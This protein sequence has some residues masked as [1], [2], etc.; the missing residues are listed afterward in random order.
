MKKYLNRVLGLLVL[1]LLPLISYAAP[2]QSYDTG[3][4]Q[5]AVNTIWIV[6]DVD[7]LASAF[8][9]T[10][11]IFTAS[12]FN[13]AVLFACLLAIGGMTISLVTQ[14]NMQVAN[15]IIFLVLSLCL[16]LPKT[17]VHIASYYGKDAMGHSTGG[18]IGAVKTIDVSGVPVGVAWPMGIFSNVAKKFTELFETAMQP[19]H[20]KSSYLIHGAEGYFSPIKTTLRMRDAWNIPEISSNLSRMSK[21]CLRSDSNI[22]KTMYENNGLYGTLVQSHEFSGDEISFST[23]YA[24][25]NPK[26]IPPMIRMNC[27]TAAMMLY[28]QMLSQVHPDSTLGY[29]PVAERLAKSRSLNNLMLGSS[30]DD[31][32]KEYHSVAKEVQGE[33][34]SLANL[35]LPAKTLTSSLP[36]EPKYILDNTYQFIVDRYGAHGEKASSANMWHDVQGQMQK[37]LIANAIN[38]TEIQANIVFSGAVLNCL[39]DPDKG[40]VRSGLL[41]EEGITRARVDN[42]GMA[43]MFQHF[44]HHSMNILAFIFIIMSPIMIV[45][46]IA[47]GVRGWRLT[48][49]YLVLVVWINSWLPVSV[50]ITN[51]M[52][53]GYENTVENLV[54]TLLSK[55]SAKE[56]LSPLVLHNILNGA[57][58]M[59]ASASSMLAMVPTIMLSVLTGSVYG[60]AQLAQRAG[61][62]GKDYV[63]ESKVAKDLDNSR[64]IG[65][66]EM[67]SQAGMRSANGYVSMSEQVMSNATYNSPNSVNLTDS[68]ALGDTRTKTI[69]SAIEK[70]E[71][72]DQQESMALV[73]SKNE[74]IKTG[75]VVSYGENNDE[76]Y[77]HIKNAQDLINLLQSGRRVVALNGDL[78]LALNGNA[79]GG[80]GKGKF[81]LLSLVP[82][83]GLSTGKSTNVAGTVE[84]SGLQGL[85][86]QELQGKGSGNSFAFSDLT[87]FEGTNGLSF[88]HNA[89]ETRSQFTSHL[90]SEAQAKVE[91][92]SRSFTVGSSVTYA[93]RDFGLLTNAPLNMDQLNGVIQ[94]VKSADETAGE[95]LENA[96]GKGGIDSFANAIQT[97]MGSSSYDMSTKMA[98]VGVLHEITKH[99]P[100][101]YGDQIHVQSG[102]LLSKYNH[103]VEFLNDNDA[104]INRKVSAVNAEQGLP[105]FENKS[106]ISD[107]Q[108]RMKG[109]F[110]R[111]KAEQRERMEQQRNKIHSQFNTDEDRTGRKIGNREQEIEKNIN[112]ENGLDNVARA[113]SYQ[114]R[115]DGGTVIKDAFRNFQNSAKDDDQ[116]EVPRREGSGKFW[117][118]EEGPYLAGNHNRNDGG[119]NFSTVR[120]SAGSSDDRL[121]GGAASV[122]V[123]QKMERH[124]ADKDG[125]VTIKQGGSRSWR[126]NN[127]GNLVYGK[128]A[129]AHGAIGTDGRFAIFPDEKTGDKAR[130]ALI[131]GGDKYRNLSL[132]QAIHRYAPPQENNTQQYYNVVKN[133]VGVEKKMKD[134]TPAERKVILDTMK[135]HEG[136]RVGKIIKK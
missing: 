112:T 30:G 69:Q 79:S 136:Y 50:G 97:V 53:S 84:L 129:K 73:N 14:R 52:L 42:S 2:L 49:G 47:M 128:F 101:G 86:V 12:T 106:N 90:V 119:G 123:P 80:V 111:S 82:G 19:A 9:A 99:D 115:S 46:I 71:K 103:M 116:R 120:Y 89:S 85:N 113:A 39:G 114:S 87:G 8:E 54:Q 68:E 131:F 38:S 133:A 132:K 102:Q 16:F 37:L 45:V 72:V 104:A 109:D 3:A 98:M 1:W 22:R 65:A 66:K 10:A 83:L 51:Y 20:T 23:G 121:T 94:Q 40:C 108:S 100:T 75:T 78:N 130:E 43:S 35:L 95:I 67:I 88:N 31:K 44:L 33:M 107:V 15:Y 125:H 70:G 127:S 6:G 7:I 126:N 24:P 122:T 36:V 91:S 118:V 48:A 96:L 58:D 41:M 17:T 18:T 28:A 29:S 60:M 117:E 63:D 110:D 62:T 27:S 56:V 105:D 11:M 64:E 61:M 81:S 59:I 124:Y 26:N 76:K 55:G 135:K 134:Y 57:S 5:S 92:L 93:A 21:H 74:L 34:S 25:G 32:T 13:S 77:H 4:K